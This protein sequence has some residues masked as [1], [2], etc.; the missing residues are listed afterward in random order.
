[1][2]S[3]SRSIMTVVFSLFLM[4]TSTLS[5]L[6]AEEETEQPESIQETAVPEAEGIEAEAVS[7]NEENDGTEEDVQ[8]IAENSETDETVIENENVTSH[9]FPVINPKVV[10]VG[11][12]ISCCKSKK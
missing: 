9:L 7:E 11:N 4:F 1:M 3:K 10:L 6:M 5:P 2:S 12:R 8:D